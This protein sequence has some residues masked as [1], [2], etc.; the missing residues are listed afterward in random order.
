MQTNTRDLVQFYSSKAWLME[1]EQMVQP[2]APD[3]LEARAKLCDLEVEAMDLAAQAIG[4][5]NHL[6]NTLAGTERFSKA[7]DIAF[8]PTDL[9]GLKRVAEYYRRAEFIESL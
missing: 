8:S 7:L 5:L 9:G 1:L 6:V 3:D 4:Y 2:I